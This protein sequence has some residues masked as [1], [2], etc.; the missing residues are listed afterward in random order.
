MRTLSFVCLLYCIFFVSVSAQVPVPEL[1]D[2]TPPPNLPP[3]V[4]PADPVP[5]E[6]V[7]ENALP[8]DALMAPGDAL[9]P[10]AAPFDYA[11]ILNLD[12]EVGIIKLSDETGLQVL[13]M[14]EMYTER[15]VLPA[16]NLPQV[17]L[18]F[19]S[20]TPMTK[21]EALVALESLL[22]MNG[23][24]LTKINQRF[25][26]AV[27]AVGINQQVPVWL[28]GS[29]GAQPPSEKIYTTL[30]QLDYLPVK[31]LMTNLTEFGSKSFK[32][33]PFEKANN[34]LVTDSMLN[35]QRM[36]MLIK[37]LDRPVV[38]SSEKI[39]FIKTDHVNVADIQRRLSTMAE[40]SLK[41]YLGGNTKFD[42]DERSGQLIVVTH[43][44]NEGL[45]RAII[46]NLD[47]RVEPDTSS[48]VFDI[49]NAN[50]EEVQKLLGEIIG[51]QKKVQDQAKKGTGSTRSS[52][53]TAAA[54]PATSTPAKPA[55]NT[56]PKPAASATATAEPGER[57]LQFSEFVT[58]VPD[59]RSNSILAY[60]TKSD[61]AYIE[62]LIDQI[63][64]E[65]AQVKIE[66]IIAEVTLSRNETRGL[67][68]FRAALD[69]KPDPV[70]FPSS[71]GL[72]NRTAAIITQ[73][74]LTLGTRQGNVYL[75]AI[76]DIAK[77]DG[78]VEVLSTPN[79][80]ATHNQE[81]EINVS[82]AEPIVTGVNSDTTGINY[83]SNIQYRDIGIQL[84]VKPLIGSNG[85][86]QMEIEQTVENVVGRIDVDQQNQNQPIIGKR[87]ANSYVSVKDLDVIVLAGLQESK[88]SETTRKTPILG[89]LPVL[90]KFFTRTIIE[91]TKRDLIFFIRPEIVF[92]SRSIEETI[93]R[94]NIN[95]ELKEA[96]RSGD[97]IP[98]EDAQ[99]AKELRRQGDNPDEH[100]TL[101]GPKVVR[102]NTTTRP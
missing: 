23:I 42:Q 94:L 32:P 88:P 82:Q 49:K 58:T 45:I 52:G 90:N 5:P 72:H 55:A 101:P 38:M 78:R 24:A 70:Q 87:S 96:I 69:N 25:W 47:V 13:K 68:I 93:E 3:D 26:K 1:P 89:S 37:N 84:K 85:M 16:Q 44:A 2:P 100:S 65:L 61:L 91:D 83:R 15:N 74:A 46:E 21:G 75:D 17:Q 34:V 50:A 27:P 62:K 40:G 66:V 86:I 22:S 28:A 43:Q 19:D 29:P 33:V 53:T 4:A 31:D 7:P 48:K 73:D 35:L 81:A 18:N 54:K 60:G 99:D 56:A 95:D 102:I 51:Q 6:P 64:V 10:S 71:D 12:E 76:L 80:V 11:G 20:R 9:L 63:D 59:P 98:D 92:G 79:I 77:N 30:F 39:L 67:D 36:E 41:R 8:G 57:N 97:L 14:I